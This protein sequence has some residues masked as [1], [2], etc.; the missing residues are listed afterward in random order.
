[1]KYALTPPAKEKTARASASALRISR[2]NACAVCSSISGRQLPKARAMVEGLVSKERDIG[3][4]YYTNAS[5]EIL[6]LLKSAQSNA[7]NRGLDT[8]RLIVNASAHQ[9]FGFFRPRRFK[10]KRQKR[11]VTNIQIVLQEK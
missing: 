2:K 7:E 5:K 6:D 10:M 9:G 8:E 3:G 11:K 4:K 1:M